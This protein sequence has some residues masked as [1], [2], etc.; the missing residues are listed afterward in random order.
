MVVRGDNGDWSEFPVGAVEFLA[1][2]DG[3]TIDVSGMPGD[4]PSDFP[5]VLGLSDRIETEPDLQ[6]HV[7]SDRP[8]VPGGDRCSAG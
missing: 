6:A 3:R 8:Q 7:N 5:E 2:V 4:F 1:G